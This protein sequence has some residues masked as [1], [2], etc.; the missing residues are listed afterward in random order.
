VRNRSPNSWI[1]TREKT[2]A[3]AAAISPMNFAAGGCVDVVEEPGR[4][5]EEDAREERQHRAVQRVENKRTGQVPPPTPP[6]Q[7]RHRPP[8]TFRA[9]GRSTVFRRMEVR[10]TTGSARA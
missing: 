2:N 6:A 5:N 1:D 3:A 10:M 8:C 7:A 9:S 4:R